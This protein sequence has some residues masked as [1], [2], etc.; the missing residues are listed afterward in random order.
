MTAHQV[1]ELTHAHVAIVGLGLMGGSL[2]LALR[3]HVRKLTAVD[4]DADTRR[5]AL[6][7]RMVDEA[8]ADVQEGIADA[9]IVILATPVRTILA[10]LAQLPRWRSQGCIVIDLGST[11]GRICAAMDALPPEFAAIGGHPMCGKESSGL[12]FA[13]ENLYRDETFILCRTR[14]TKEH[15]ERLILSMLERIGAKPLFLPAEE[16]DRL[17]ALVSHLPYFLAAFLMQQNAQAAAS[18]GRLWEVSASGFRDTARLSGSQPR[19][20][21]D[22]VETNRVEILGVLRRHVSHVESLI[23]IVAEQEDAA[24]R[25]WL[26]ARQAEYDAYRRALR[27]RR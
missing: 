5:M 17:V 16:H 25:D 27:D 14:R 2:A 21:H 1:P 23:K 26:Q 3:P 9:D 11:K 18:E 20:L 7:R 8:L 12:S 15:T 19:M 13:Q 24:L 4:V 22:I 6:E 10:I